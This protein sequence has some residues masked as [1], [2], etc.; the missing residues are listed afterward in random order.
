MSGYLQS[1]TQEGSQIKY[2]NLPGEYI[3]KP[4]RLDKYP[5]CRSSLEAYLW[6]NNMISDNNLGLNLCIMPIVCYIVVILNN[7][8]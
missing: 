7:E 2:E 3:W 8:I 5:G 4:M 6:I 1:I